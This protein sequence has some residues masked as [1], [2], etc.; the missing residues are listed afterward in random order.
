MNIL[1]G[2]EDWVLQYETYA[3]YVI[4]LFGILHPLTENPW[5]LFTLGIAITMLGIPLGYTVVVVSTAIGMVLL[6][7]SI[8][9]IHRKSDYRLQHTKHVK[10]ALDWLEQTPSW[11]HMIV[12][13]MP[14]VPTYPIKA[15]LP[16]TNMSFGRYVYTLGGSYLFLLLANSLIFFGVL[17]LIGLWIPQW[18]SVLLLIVVAVL[19]YFGNDLKK[20]V[21]SN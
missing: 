16:L 21:Q 19:I 3:I 10:Q 9:W 18:L 2:I 13:G 4:F 1:Q 7:G 14:T 12:I 20:L 8:H 11:K 5:S 17:G 6:Y 15:A